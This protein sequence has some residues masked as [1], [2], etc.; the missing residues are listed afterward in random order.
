MAYPS[1]ALDK[2]KATTMSTLAELRR[3]ASTAEMLARTFAES[4]PVSA[5]AFAGYADD[6][7][8]LVDTA[9]NLAGAVGV[10]ATAI[11]DIEDIAQDNLDLGR[12]D[13]NSI[14][15]ICQ[16]NAVKTAC[17]AS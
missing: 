15:H 6:V 12:D 10:L 14:L 3:R 2:S 16:T 5:R 4:N 9:L 17:E 1:V 7:L 13:L 11:R 8:P